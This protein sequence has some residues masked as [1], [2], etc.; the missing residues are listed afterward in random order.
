MR[1]GASPT[2]IVREVGIATTK[3]INQTMLDSEPDLPSVI[4]T[5]SSRGGRGSEATHLSPGSRM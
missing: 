1:S 3:I 5:S 2:L 4:P